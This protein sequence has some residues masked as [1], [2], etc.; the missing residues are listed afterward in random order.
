MK[1]L[2]MRLTG[3]LV[4]WSML[5][6]CS[7]SQNLATDTSL[8]VHVDALYDGTDVIVRWVPGNYKT[9]QHGLVHGYRLERMLVGSA[10]NELTIGEML[11]SQTILDSMLL[12]LPEMDWEPLADQ[13]DMAGVAAGVIYGDSL[14][15]INYSDVSFSQIVN[16]NAERENRFSFALFAADNSFQTAEAMGI[17][18]KDPNIAIDKEYVYSVK[19]NNPPNG[20]AIVNSV[21]VSTSPGSG[22]PQPESISAITGDHTVLLSWDTENILEHYTSFC[23]ERSSDNGQTFEAAHENPLVFGEQD[24]MANSEV[25]FFDSLVSNDVTYIYRVKGKSPFGLMG[26]YSD[27]VHVKGTP[28]SLGVNPALVDVTEQTTGILKLA[29]VFPQEQEDSITGFDI[30]RSDKANGEFSKINTNTLSVSTRNYEDTNPMSVNYYKVQGKDINNYPLTSNAVLGQP[31]DENAPAA[32]TGLFGTCSLSGTVTLNWSPNAEEDLLG[33]RVYVSNTPDGDFMQITSQWIND[34]SYQYSINLNT[35]TE[36]V[37]FSVKALDKREN[38][39]LLAVPCTVNR[40]DKI[41]PGSPNITNVTAEVGQVHFEWELSSSEDVEE[42]RFQRK[43]H[44]VPGWA[45]LVQFDPHLPIYAFTDSTA[46]ERIYSDYRLIAID[47]AGLAGYSKTVKAKPI[48]NGVRDTIFDFTGTLVPDVGVNLNWSYLKDVDLEGF[49]IYRSIDGGPLRVYGFLPFNGTYNY[50]SNT[51]IPE[52]SYYD[53]DLDM[54]NVPVQNN[55]SSPY[56]Y[57]TTYTGGSIS[58]VG[59]TVNITPPPQNTNLPNPTLIGNHNFTYKVMAK[60]LDGAMSPLS[61]EVIIQL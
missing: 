13:D 40:P 25:Q 16:L 33:Y 52:F 6:L 5:S 8:S 61:T 17:G 35:L 4:C 26:P 34:T 12:P 46:S 31:N 3:L 28:A 24:G 1:S 15:V 42:Y 43:P 37:Y 19:L 38:Y 39:S 44:G 41:A 21:K 23:V 27:T 29:W 11:N 51:G 9:W 18:I 59:G 2:F 30:Y 54:D 32:P 45:D 48:D 57:L 49:Q 22:L 47:D 55:Y 56:D 36:E 10:S 60:F 58:T 50:N 53:D 7:F 20:V 14:E